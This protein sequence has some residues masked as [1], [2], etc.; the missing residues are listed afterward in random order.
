MKSI[1]AVSPAPIFPCSEQING[2]GARLA[3]ASPDPM[4]SIMRLSSHDLQ[5]IRQ[6]LLGADPNGRVWLFGSRADDSRRGGDIDLYFE[7]GQAVSLKAS[8]RLEYRLTALCGSKVDLL[9]R[10]PG[11]AEQPIH[12]IAKRGV[13]L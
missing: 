13:P 12:A 11:Q 7:V 6:A 8:L 3:L 4:H 10:N 9:V 5:A 2:K 1:A